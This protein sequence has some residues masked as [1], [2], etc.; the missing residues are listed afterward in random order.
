MVRHIDSSGFT[1]IVRI[2]LECP[3]QKRDM[4]TVHRVVHR[5]DDL[6]GK[7]RLLVVVHDNDLLPVIGYRVQVICPGNI[8]QVQNVLLKTRSPKAYGSL[9]KFWTDTGILSDCSGHLIYV[10]AG[11]LTELR[12]RV[13]G[14]YS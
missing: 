5:L 6:L 1:G 2:F 14:R 4:F 8:H 11:Y 10:G 12:D 9:Q 7:T 3:T 13:D